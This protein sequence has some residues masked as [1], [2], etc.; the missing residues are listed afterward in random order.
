V[1]G[2]GCEPE[3]AGFRLCTVRE[4]KEAYDTARFAVIEE[5]RQAASSRRRGRGMAI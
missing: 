4:L 2:V 5:A 1:L 3:E